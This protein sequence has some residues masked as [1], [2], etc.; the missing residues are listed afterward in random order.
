MQSGIMQCGS[1]AR[2]CQELTARSKVMTATQQSTTTNDARTTIS[3]VQLRKE[4]PFSLEQI[5]TV[6]SSTLHIPILSVQE[7]CRVGEGRER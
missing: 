6:R 1:K 2:I 3:R 7:V 5:V 4:K